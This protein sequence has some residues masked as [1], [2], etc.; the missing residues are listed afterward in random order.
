[1]VDGGVAVVVGLKATLSRTVYGVAA[2]T[3][4]AALGKT[5]AM[6]FGGRES[7][8][9]AC[10]A[11]ATHITPRHSKALPTTI[12]IGLRASPE[13]TEARWG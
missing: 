7:T 9:A 3:G 1:M 5:K 2:P 8:S 12:P 6:A 11:C 4:Y 10:D 13:R